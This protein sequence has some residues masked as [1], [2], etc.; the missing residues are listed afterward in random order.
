M[1]EGSIVWRG[2]PH[3]PAPLGAIWSARRNG[4][5][6]VVD[7]AGKP[8][9]FGAVQW[10]FEGCRTVW[11]HLCRIELLPL[12]AVAKMQRA[13]APAQIATAPATP[14]PKEGKTVIVLPV[15]PDMS[16]T[17]VYRELLAI[18]EQRPDWHVV[19]LTRNEQ[20]PRH[21]E[22]EQL[23]DRVTFL[24]RDGITRAHFRSLGWVF[25]RRCAD[26]IQIYSRQ[27]DPESREF[28]GKQALCDARHPGNALALADLLRPLRAKHIHVYAS[29]WPA[30]V[31]MGAAHLL[32]VP[33]SI[34]SYVDFE[35]PYSHKLLT[36]KVARAKFFRV[37][38]QFCQDRL[39]AMHPDLPT[40][41]A[42][43]VY[44]GIDLNNW[45]DRATPAGN[46]TLVSAA[47]IVEKKGLHLMPE[48]LALLKQRGIAC[49]WRVI[50]DGPELKR[51]RELCVQHG[52]D[53]QVELLGARDNQTVR[54]ALLQADAAV[55]PCIVAKDGERDG[56]PIFFI[57]AMAL[58]V[59]VVTTPI[60]GIPELI[61]D[62]DTGFLHATND[63][64]AL[65]DKLAAVLSGQP[66]AQEVGLRGRDEVHR[67]LD[68]RK[69]ATQ[70]I[71]CIER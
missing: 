64:A 58:G 38:T 60:S 4:V 66:N 27:Q 47:R 63:V 3:A 12:I 7:D 67:T 57:E 35:F 44:L 9:T 55:L 6:T 52:I 21:R 46:G 32:N 29:T 56:I 45:Q 61:R 26:L 65:A 42:P 28:L 15:L 70:L 43:V 62:G 30:N 17:F 54:E 59:P 18:L 39:R 31:A 69:S 1:S 33:F 53:K 2:H 8:V 41:R 68:V 11:F 40:E 19:A 50:G 13:P 10:L 20:A 25:N 23:L 51:I 37:V 22:A 48:A 24:P 14:A 34:S 16:H 49:N 71:D 36:E 5:A